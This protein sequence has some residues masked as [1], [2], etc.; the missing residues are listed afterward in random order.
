MDEANANVVETEVVEPEEGVV[1]ATEQEGDV[2][3]EVRLRPA[4]LADFVGQQTVRENLEV[5]IEAA[6]LRGEPLDHAV[7]Y[8]PPG[9]GKTTLANIIANEMEA[10]IRVTS[11]PAI[12][13]PSDLASI[14]TGLQANDVLFIDEIHRLSKPVEEV[15]YPAMEDFFLSWV[16]GKGLSARSINL[17][18]N[19][20]TL[21]GATTRYSMVSAPLR[22]RFGSVYRLDYY[23]D[24]EMLK[25]VM[26]N[27]GV[28]GVE[29]EGE[30]LVEVAMRARGTPRIANRL[31]RR[32]RD[33]ALVRA[34]NVVTGA[35]AREALDRLGVDARGL[36][37][38]D[39]RLLETLIHKFSG[40]P[41]GLSTLSTSMGEDADTVTEV[42]EPFLLQ[43]GFIQRTPRGRVATKLAYEYLEWPYNGKNGLGQLELQFAP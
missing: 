10:S 42:L 23:D 32:C 17:R 28:L 18:V 24:E 5:S 22:D 14:L 37:E 16:V 39:H 7:I 34:G 11:G 1:S 2:E 19:S 21:V 36:D 13:R 43:Q 8:G 26:R 20:F 35:V 31:L 12:E 9:L 27:S 4:K 41:V 30:G 29:A 3:S 25:L 40:G 33:Y 6:K 38:A 15:L